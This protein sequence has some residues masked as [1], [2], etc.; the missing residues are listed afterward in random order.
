MPDVLEINEPP[1]IVINKKYKLKLFDLINV[2][3]ELDKLLIVLIIKSSPLFL[4]K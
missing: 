4:L 1:I 3:P 2:R